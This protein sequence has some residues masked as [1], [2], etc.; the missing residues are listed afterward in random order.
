MGL[1]FGFGLMA[2]RPLKKHLAKLLI[3]IE[4]VRLAVVRP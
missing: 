2:R 4:V 1:K 3:C